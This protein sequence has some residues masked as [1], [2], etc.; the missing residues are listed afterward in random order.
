MSALQYIS[1]NLLIKRATRS[2]FTF[3]YYIGGIACLLR[4]T[5]A[6]AFQYKWNFA[7]I[8]YQIQANGTRTLTIVNLVAI[9]TGMVLAL[10]FSVGLGR[11][12]LKL[13][14]GQIIG[15]AIMRELGPV[16]TSLMIAARVGSG[17]ASE[18]G[19]MVVT[20]QVLAIEAM[21]AN[22]VAKLVFP[23]FIAVMI[24]APLLTIVADLVGVVGGM[25][26]TTS[27]AG[28]TRQFYM[29]QIWKTVHMSDF[30]HGIAKTVVFGAFVALIACYE[31]L[32]TTG[33]TEGVGRSTTRAVV[34]SSIMIFV[35]DFFLTKI[36]IA[37]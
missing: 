33:G 13:Y 30:T 19:S 26:V 7:E 1:E 27:E 28:V 2:V 31:G 36:L 15:I 5:V 23:R 11:F 24:S 10:Q 6:S 12:G 16:L 35:L 21:G 3:V 34:F 14:T 18:L 22:P 37:M 17:I 32:N 8:A 4:R 9:F 20:E 25:F 29:D